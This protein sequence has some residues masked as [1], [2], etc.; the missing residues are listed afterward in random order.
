MGGAEVKK[1]LERNSTAEITR[2]S[3]VYGA[4]YIYGDIDH[5]WFAES[6]LTCI[7]TFN[8]PRRVDERLS[9]PSS[10]DNIQS[11]EV[12]S[13]LSLL[14]HR[15]EEPHEFRQ[16]RAVPGGVCK[17]LANPFGGILTTGDLFEVHERMPGFPPPWSVVQLLLQCMSVSHTIGQFVHSHEKAVRK[18]KKPES[19]LERDFD[20]VECRGY[21]LLT[22][23]G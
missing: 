4:R 7:L 1:A 23:E 17:L 20:G 19:E 3:D 16:L 22:A 11:D 8:E 5:D 15:S 18:E 14:S 2:Y 12:G 9:R 6:G 13:F 10:E 21:V